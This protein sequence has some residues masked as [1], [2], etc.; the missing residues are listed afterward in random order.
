MRR[1]IGW[2]AGVLLGV[3]AIAPGLAQAASGFQAGA[4]GADITPPPYT[5]ESDAA[6]VPA[7]GTSAA[8]VAQLW[9]GPRKFAFEKPYIDT[10]GVGRYAPGDPYCDADHSGRYEAPYIAGGSGQNHWP[11]AVEP[12]NGPAAQAIVVQV[13][14]TR[15]AIVSVDSIGLFN[16]TMDRIRAEVAT[17][18]PALTR[19]FVSSTH[20]E[21]APDPIGLWGPEASDLPEHPETPAATSSGVDEYYM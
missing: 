1:G 21:S 20:D 15:A 11:T 4:A 12:G 19:I 8:Q 17:L 2:M 5:T 10:L 16:V 3:V 6:F 13:G 18:D 7:C 9:P 14:A